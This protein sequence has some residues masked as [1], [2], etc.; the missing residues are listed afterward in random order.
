MIRQETSK[1]SELYTDYNPYSKNAIRKL[2][3]NLVHY[4]SQIH[5]VLSMYTSGLA[6]LTKKNR[7]NEDQGKQG[8]SFSGH[9][10]VLEGGQNHSTHRFNSKS[11]HTF[12]WDF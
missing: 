10:A 4:C 1:R 5:I 6:R 8:S 12:I 2:K 7:R 3:N 11:I 9:Q